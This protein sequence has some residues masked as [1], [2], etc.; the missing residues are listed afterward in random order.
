MHD[1]HD[2]AHPHTH[3]HSDHDHAS[4]HS[5]VVSAHQL[6]EQALRELLIE[7]DVLSAEM[8]AR[9]IDALDSRSPALGAKVVA[10]AWSDPAYEARLMADPRKA[11]EELGIDFGFIADLGVVK[12]T[13][14]RHN[15]IVCTL[16]SCYPKGLLG[17]PP[18]WYKSSA[19]RQRTI[20][21]PRAVLAEFGTFLPE[22]TAITVVDSTADV[23]Y[24]VLPMRPAGTEGWSEAELASL[25][26]RDSLI[27][28]GAPL[29]ASSRQT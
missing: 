7:K 4:D 21:D 14:G 25:V 6:L 26:T 28:V 18:A 11:L 19:Y 9:R 24:I 3:S 15:V 27:G 12:N 2:H 17:I 10:R 23:R 5:D 29:P 16:C 13:P 22:D 1:N 20:T 8:I